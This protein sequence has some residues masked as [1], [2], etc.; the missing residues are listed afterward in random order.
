MVRKHTS[1]SQ[2]FILW[3]VIPMPVVRC[4][5][6]RLNSLSKHFP[7]W[8]IKSSCRGKPQGSLLCSVALPTFR[9]SEMMSFFLSDPGGEGGAGMASLSSWGLS[10]LI[11]RWVSRRIS[12]FL[13]HRQDFSGSECVGCYAGRREDPLPI[14]WGGDPRIRQATNT[15]P[16]YYFL[17]YILPTPL[18]P[19]PLLSFWL[20]VRFLSSFA[21]TSVRLLFPWRRL[22][23]LAAQIALKHPIQQKKRVLLSGLGGRGREGERRMPGG[24][25]GG[26]C[27]DHTAEH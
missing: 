7:P 20:L 10:A 14:Q 8:S 18:N 13:P 27:W 15:Y 2:C 4:S 3:H 26:A 9:G 12:W 5:Q 25:R 23:S 17:L 24:W 16:K 1:S 22:V 11:K 21:A 6:H 19:L